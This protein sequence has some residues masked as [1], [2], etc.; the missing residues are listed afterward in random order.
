[1]NDTS[2]ISKVT[3]GEIQGVNL[4]MSVCICECYD[5]QQGFSMNTNGKAVRLYLQERECFSAD[6][7]FGSFRTALNG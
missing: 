7:Y 1:M 6:Y 5:V 2:L 4:P 3:G